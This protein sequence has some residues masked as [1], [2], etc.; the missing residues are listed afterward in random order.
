MFR[1]SS[2]SVREKGPSA[3]N[4]ST[5]PCCAGITPVR[6]VARLG[7]HIAGLQTAFWAAGLTHSH[8]PGS[9]VFVPASPQKAKSHATT[10]IIA[11]DPE[12]R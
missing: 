3:V 1:L 7:L 2:L 11:D 6:N 12:H 10:V 9:R 8:W 5:T 4:V